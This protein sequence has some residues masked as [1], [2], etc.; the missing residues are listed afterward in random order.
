MKSLKNDVKAWLL[1]CAA[2]YEYD[3]IFNGVRILHWCVSQSLGLYS[4]GR[5]RKP[6]SVWSIGKHRIK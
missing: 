3:P 5:G 2:V 1:L 6:I 4:M